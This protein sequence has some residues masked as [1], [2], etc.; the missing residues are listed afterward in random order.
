M[1]VPDPLGSSFFQMEVTGEKTSE[2]ALR[3]YAQ[4]AFSGLPAFLILAIAA[5]LF[6]LPMLIYGP[7]VDGHDTYEHLNY[8]YH[9][10]QQFWKGEWYPRWLTGMNH[11]LGSPSLFV[12]PPLPSY[13]Y[14]LLEPAGKIGHVNAFRMEEFLVLFGSGV[15]AFLWL[16]TMVD[17]GIALAGAVFYMLMPY[18]LAVDYYRRTALSECWALAW[19][20]LILYLGAKTILRKERAHQVGL[21]VACALLILSHVVSALMFFLIP[22]AVAISSSPRGQ[23]LR[24]LLR[25][26]GP[27]LLGV[28]LSSFYLVPALFHAR[29]FPVSRLPLW[30]NLQAN[31]LTLRKLYESSGFIRTI[32][33]TTFDMIALCAICGVLVLLKSRDP[34]SRKQASF[35][36]AV[37]IIPTFLMSSLSFPVWKL[38]PSLFAAVQYP[39][40]FNVVLCLASAAIVVVFL[41]EIWSLSRLSRGV[42]LLLLFAATNPWLISYGIIW[43]R[44]QTQTAQQ[45][46][47]VN[48]DDGWFPAWSVPGIDETSALR[49]SREPKVRFLGIAG[50]S[51]VRRWE[52]RHIEFQTDSPTGGPVMINQFY[53]PSWTASAAGA[54]Q[55]LEVK[56]AMP[57]GLLELEVPGG[58]QEVRV[59]MP[60]GLSERVG[61]WVSALC[62]VLSAMLAWKK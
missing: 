6:A 33:F 34:S 38:F 26:A 28:G 1:W 43:R 27:M 4:K 46:P 20:P 9:F 59:D 14:A 42:A 58:R 29:Y 54:V 39:W 40:R 31:L 52:P 35:W 15:C 56:A 25:V 60:I 57:E 16:S 24:F 61:R 17:W 50:T 32:A 36:L 45:K 37:C 41:S 2:Q 23:K 21:A 49:A 10:S 44:Y 12:Y 18:H 22:M 3:W 53:Y 13:V 30:S 62:V 7:M 19:M 8:S 51:N 11:G 55:P 5:L 48:D 47:P